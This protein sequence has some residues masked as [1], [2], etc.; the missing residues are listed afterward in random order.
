MTTA[1]AHSTVL[2]PPQRLLQ[3]TDTEL[4]RLFG[5]RRQAIAQWRERGLPASRQA[6]AATLGAISDLL[7][8]ML[9]RERIPGIARKPAREYGGLTMLE[10]VE[11]DRHEE[12]HEKVRRSFDW[13]STA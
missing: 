9:K 5:V 12:L 6:K 2:D 10:M 11:R 13:A 1:T 7:E 3:L 8:R 4:G